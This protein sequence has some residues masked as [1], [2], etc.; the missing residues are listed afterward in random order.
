MAGSAGATTGVV[1]GAFF[2]VG[3]FLL[4][5]AATIIL[6]IIATFTP[7]N[8]VQGYGEEYRIPALMLKSLYTNTSYTYSN[9]SIAPNTQLSSLFTTVSENSGQQNVAGGLIDNMYGTGP[10]NDSTNS[11]RRRRASFGLSGLYSI[12]RGRLFYSTA[13]SKRGDKGKYVN[14]TDLSNCVKSR[15]VACNALFA[16]TSDFREWTPVP[17]SMTYSIVTNATSP[18]TYQVL[19][20]LR[21]FAVRPS[22]AASL[23]NSSLGVSSSSLQSQ[24]LAGCQYIGPLS[25]A[26]IAAILASQATQTTTQPS[27]TLASG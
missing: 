22:S 2:C 24:L 1:M 14:S 19:S 21:V 12:G 15:L 25:Q 23:A 4:G 6:S 16:S 9:G 26:S 11:K 17:S 20:I 13:C 27:S 5:I 18:P 7:N 10:G 3:L 8:S